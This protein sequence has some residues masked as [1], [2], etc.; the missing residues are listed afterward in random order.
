MKG[1]LILC[2]AAECGQISI[3][4]G[5]LELRSSARLAY[6]VCLLWKL[7]SPQN[8]HGKQISNFRNFKK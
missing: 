3:I 5:Y 8:H 7:M 2:N 1:K 6:T 4:L